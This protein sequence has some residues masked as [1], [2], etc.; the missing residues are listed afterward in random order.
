VRYKQRVDGE[1]IIIPWRDEDHRFACCDCG[2]VH[3]FE[4]AVKGRNVIV[5]AT[6]NKRATAQRR[7][8]T[9]FNVTVG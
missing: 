4:F 6:R 8:W 9:E 5:R 3:D 7:R 2:L 1:A